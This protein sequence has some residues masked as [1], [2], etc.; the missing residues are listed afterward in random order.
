MENFSR[1]EFERL[2]EGTEVLTDG[3]RGPSVYRTVDDKVVKIFRQKGWLTSNRL[4]P[5]ALR[6]ERCANRLKALG[7]ASVS[8]EK[9]AAC[10]DLNCHLAIYPLLPGETIRDLAN[11]ADEQ[12]RALTRLPGYLCALHRKGVYCRALHLGQVL[13]QADGSFALLDLHSTQF[14]TTPVPVKRR[15]NN[16]INTLNYA[17]DYATLTRHGLTRFFGDYLQCSQLSKK[18]KAALLSKLKNS[19]SFPELKQALSDL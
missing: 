17:E 13:A 11:R 10:R 8:V 7:F 1:H 4:S 19:R 9:I 6:F 2:V 18:H 3:E 12:R 5:Y 15:L 14:S 16:F